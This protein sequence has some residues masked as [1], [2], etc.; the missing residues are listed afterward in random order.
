[1]LCDLPVPQ[2]RTDTGGSIVYFTGCWFYVGQVKA[3]SREKQEEDAKVPEEN[4][5]R[6]AT[7]H[8][9]V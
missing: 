5:T 8:Q 3:I 2:T 7:R 1:M 4:N 9:V 6:H